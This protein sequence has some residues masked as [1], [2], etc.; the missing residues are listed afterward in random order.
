[1]GH[2][3]TGLHKKD[4]YVFVSPAPVTTTILHNQGRVATRDTRHVAPY[5]RLLVVTG[6]FVSLPEAYRCARAW[7]ERTRGYSSKKRRGIELAR[8]FGVA[9]YTEDVPPPAPTLRAYL[10]AHAPPAYLA[11]FDTLAR[12]EPQFTVA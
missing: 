6:P 10:D 7:V 2:P 3:F 11:A 9:C 12:N 8:Q 5:W 4:T 1:M